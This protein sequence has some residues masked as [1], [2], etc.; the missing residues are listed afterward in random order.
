MIYVKTI[1]KPKYLPF[2][3]NHFYNNLYWWNKILNY[4]GKTICFANWI[5][6]GIPHVEDIFEESG[7]LKSS[8]DIFDTL[9]KR[10]NWLCEYKI[11]KQIFT[12][13]ELKYDF[14]IIT[15]IHT[16]HLPITSHQHN[17]TTFFSRFIKRKLQVPGTQLKLE[18]R[19]KI[20]QKQYENQYT[21]RKFKILKTK[22][23]RSLVTNYW[24]FC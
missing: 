10:T 15:Y 1:S 14:S 12:K 17:T 8:P 3:P 24:T 23:Y 22:P 4:I 20:G 13:F 7:Y 11:I 6:S 16:K 5:K 21:Y 19:I 18:K 9:R 2:L